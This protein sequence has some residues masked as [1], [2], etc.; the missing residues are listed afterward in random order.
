MINQ[1]GLPDVVPL[2]PALG[3]IEGLVAEPGLRPE[4]GTAGPPAL[5][6]VV[7]IV[8]G[9]EIMASPGFM[10]ELGLIP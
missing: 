1:Q 7:P 8:P 9:L 3:P 5:L 10:P 2:K 4:P 6:E